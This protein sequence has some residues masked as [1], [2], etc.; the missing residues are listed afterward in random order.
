MAFSLMISIVLSV[1]CFSL[2]FAETSERVVIWKVIEPTIDTEVLLDETFDKK[3]ET[4][5]AKVQ[6]EKRGDYD[7]FWDLQNGDSL[8]FCGINQVVNA[9]GIQ[10]Q[11]IIYRHNESG[12]KYKYYYGWRDWNA[13]PEESGFE[14]ERASE[15]CEKAL[16]LLNRLGLSGEYY[17]PK[18]VSFT[19]FGSMNGTTKSMAAVFEE[20]LEGLPIRWS[21]EALT[22]D[23]R[24]AMAEQN[25][26]EV[27][28][29]DEEG[30]LRLEAYWC[31]FEPSVRGQVLSL[32]EAM[33]QFE[34]VGLK[35]DQLENCWFL[36]SDGK[37]AT[38]T[39][40]YRYGN[41]YLSAMD[42]TWLQTE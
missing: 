15:I 31:S 14:A 24:G 8:P 35:T 2:S 18:P 22:F 7:R 41:T 20:T 13:I 33:E 34:S 42:G 16:D 1:C 40:A 25:Y 39:L 10:I 6:E 37:E 32:E 11:L 5:G 38:A 29:S 12:G 26:A 19:T 23:D 30:L 4:N 36:N 27:N 28:Y 21:T 9:T 17:E 3:K